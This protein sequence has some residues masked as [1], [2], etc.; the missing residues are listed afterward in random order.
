MMLK[1]ELLDFPFQFRISS[2]ES[3][4]LLHLNTLILIIELILRFLNVIS[5]LAVS[6]GWILKV[7]CL[8]PFSQISGMTFTMMAVPLCSSPIQRSRITS[9]IPSSPIKPTILSMPRPSFILVKT[10]GRYNKNTKVLAAA[11]SICETGTMA[12]ALALEEIIVTTRGKPN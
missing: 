9:T 5:F 7:G 11:L 12:E 4:L 2:C 6:N 10:N 8:L 1:S 3:K